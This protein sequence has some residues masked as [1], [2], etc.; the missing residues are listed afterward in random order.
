MVKNVLEK[1]NLEYI[2]Q[3]KENL[4]KVLQNE[5]WEDL[6]FED[7][8]FLVNEIA[9][10]MK[11]FTP[12]PKDIIETDV[13][14]RILDV[15]EIIKEI[16]EDEDLKRLLEY[17]P[18][19]RKL[20]NGECISSKELLELENE[21]KS[22]RPEITINNIQKETDFILFLRE[23]IGITREKDPQELIEERF[24]KH[25]ID[26]EKYNERQLNFL[27]TLKKVFAQRK[28]IEIADIFDDPFDLSNVSQFNNEKLKDIINKC[29][30]IKMC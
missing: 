23:I 7:I 27:Y 22:L 12:K 15:G 21:L 20:K 2:Q 17:N 10:A 1:D 16:P 8:E 24:K 28:H 19:A 3:N 4:T 14:D 13:P 25:I 26:N 30:E 18:V 11:Y 6:T 9:P 5:F 29:N